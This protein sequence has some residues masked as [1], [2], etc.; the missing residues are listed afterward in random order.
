MYKLK[1]YNGINNGVDN[2]IILNDLIKENN[3]DVLGVQELVRFQEESFKIKM[4]YDYK[5]VGIV[6][7]GFTIGGEFA[8]GAGSSVSKIIEF[9]TL[10]DFEVGDLYE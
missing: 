10:N 5:I 8:Y 1:R 3:I 9:L 7:Y 2:T 6:T 4:S